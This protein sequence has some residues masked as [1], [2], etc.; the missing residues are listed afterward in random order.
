MWTLL[1]YTSLKKIGDRIRSLKPHYKLIASGLILA[2]ILFIGFRSC[3]KDPVP[4]TYDLKGTQ[5]AV[6]AVEDSAVDRMEGIN[7]SVD[8]KRDEVDARLKNIKNKNVTAKEL[9][10][11]TK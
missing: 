10:E 6:K 4:P 3:K 11:K 5:E 1:I 7:Q 8:Q 2:V 9:E